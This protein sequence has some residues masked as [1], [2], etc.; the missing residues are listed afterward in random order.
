MPA[1]S[2]SLPVQYIESGQPNRAVSVFKEA[3]HWQRDHHNSWGNLALLY[4]NMS[5]SVGGE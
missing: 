3:I 2:G 4:E 5:E 1:L